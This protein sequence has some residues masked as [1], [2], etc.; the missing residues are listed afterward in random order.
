MNILAFDLDGTLCTQQKD[1]TKAEPLQERIEE[2][3]RLYDF[4][5]T[6]KI[7][8]ARGTTSGLDWSILTKEQLQNWGV[9]YH[10][11]IFGKPHFDFLIDDKAINPKDFF[12]D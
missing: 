3:N 9:K 12:N 4:G 2:V 5:H 10:H 6:I 11:L 8:T 1:Y 7:F